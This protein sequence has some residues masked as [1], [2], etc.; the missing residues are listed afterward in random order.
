MRD[1]SLFE[2]W[3]ITSITYANM[4]HYMKGLVENIYNGIVAV[5]IVS[6]NLSC[7][8]FFSYYITF[9]P[10]VYLLGVI[11]S[12]VTTGM[13]LS[14]V[15]I[16]FDLYIV[17]YETT[18]DGYQMFANHIDMKSMFFEGNDCM[19]GIIH[20]FEN[21]AHKSPFVFDWV[22]ERYKDDIKVVTDDSYSGALE[23][24]I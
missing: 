23:I 17:L 1:N 13:I 3:Y 9:N 22:Y 4:F 15:L 21:L 7:V 19:K 5:G 16:H 12:W 20:H 8:S 6:T 10:N 2:A 14:S 18:S 11:T 24:I